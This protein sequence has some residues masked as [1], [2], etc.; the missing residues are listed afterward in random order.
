MQARLFCCL[1]AVSL[2]APVSTDAQT[3]ALYQQ[4]A[5]T[6]AP[7]LALKGLRRNGPDLALPYLIHFT[8]GT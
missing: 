6:G 1:A 4:L 5:A 8:V 7:Q 3:V 2:F